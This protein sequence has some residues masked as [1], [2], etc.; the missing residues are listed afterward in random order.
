MNSQP[1]S[2]TIEAPVGIMYPYVSYILG[3][4][5]S[6]RSLGTS[7]HLLQLGIV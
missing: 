2:R 7:E 3:N 6:Y 4:A 1:L 5:K